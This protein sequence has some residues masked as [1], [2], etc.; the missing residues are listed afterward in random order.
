MDPSFWAHPMP[1]IDPGA[2]EGGMWSSGELTGIGSSEPW[3]GHFF[4]PT[5]SVREGKTVPP[6]AIRRL[7]KI[8]AGSLVIC[9]PHLSAGGVAREPHR[10]VSLLPSHTSILTVLGMLNRVVA[11][12][13]AEDPRLYPHIP[14]V[15]GMDISWE[16][17]A[18]AKPDLILADVS[19]RRHDAQFRRLGLPVAYLPSTTARTIEQVFDLVGQVGKLVGREQA[20]AAWIAQ[21]TQKARALDRRRI[22][23]PG[24]KI[25][26]EI[27]PQPLQSCGPDSLQGHLLTRI[28]ARNIIPSGG[29]EM[30][31]V[32]P[33]AVVNANP[34]IILHTGILSDDD[35]RRRSGWSSVNAVKTNRIYKLNQ[36]D[37]SRA[38]PGIMKAWNSLLDLLEKSP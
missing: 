23:S 38:G 19:H 15:G 16:A 12:S 30:P 13:E 34:D 21:A 26:L 10:I 6:I 27:W 36:D 20:A 2:S 3:M 7:T 17:L 22:P 11:V 37:I 9:L 14:R 32:S 25:Y 5:P 18:A 29:P 4:W 24:P 28:G 31:I 8:I 1:G 35:I 33:E